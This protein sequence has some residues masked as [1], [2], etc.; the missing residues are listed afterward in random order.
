MLCSGL[1][2]CRKSAA[3]AYVTGMGCGESDVG[4][5]VGVVIVAGSAGMVQLKVVAVGKGVVKAACEMKWLRAWVTCTVCAVNKGVAAQRV[6]C[7][8]VRVAS[9]ESRRDS[10]WW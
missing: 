4:A 8:K 6:V 9:T 1:V 7:I 3:A 2:D 5:V 10:R